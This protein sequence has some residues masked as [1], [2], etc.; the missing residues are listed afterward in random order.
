LRI[1][2]AIQP[3]PLPSFAKPVMELDAVLMQHATIYIRRILLNV[4]NEHK[5]YIIQPYTSVISPLR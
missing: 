2:A 1:Q 5:E 3:V 4:E